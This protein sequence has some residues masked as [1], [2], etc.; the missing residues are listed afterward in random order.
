MSQTTAKKYDFETGVYRPPS[1]GGSLSLLVRL[2]RNCPWNHCSFC[3]M[4][5]SEKFQVR[6]VADIKKDID[7]MAAIRDDLAALSIQS[8][9]RGG[10]SRHAAVTLIGKYPELNHHQGF[11]MLYH[12][13]SSGGKTA[14]LQDAN[15]LVMKTGQL[16]EVLEYLHCTFPSIVRVTAY[17]RS[18]TLVQ[19]SLE[20][21]KA[22]RRAGLDRLHVGLESGDDAV[23]KKVRKGATAEIHIKGGKK[24]LDAGFQ[25]SE[26]WMPGLGGR[27]RW[28]QHAE[29][30]ARVLS[31]VNPHYIRSRPFRSWPGTP[32][33]EETARGSFETLTPEEQLKELRLTIQTLSV[34]GRVCFDHAGNYWKDRRGQLLFSHSYEGYQ[35]P[36][37]KQRV[38]DRID[39]GLQVGIRKEQ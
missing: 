8:G 11:A 22:I 2:T 6:S 39:D 29:N 23:L 36:E 10:I 30:T 3:G 33:A 31:E 24:A 35:F 26:Y 17:A 21:L 14:F 7:A 18:K 25:L 27:A 38:L 13:L 12:W 19:K 5:K 32:L 20:D 34:T 1:E 15:S 16:V 37:E 9:Q 28:E 4:Y